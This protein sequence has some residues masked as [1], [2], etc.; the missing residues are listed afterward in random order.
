[1]YC[2]A[3]MMGFTIVDDY[4]ASGRIRLAPLIA[5]WL[6]RLVAFKRAILDIEDLWRRF[7]GSFLVGIY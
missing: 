4:R 3:D 2:K 7:R 6:W 1:M 5:V